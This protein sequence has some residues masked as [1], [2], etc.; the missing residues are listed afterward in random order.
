MRKNA[1]GVFFMGVTI[2][3]GSSNRTKV[4]V[5]GALC[6]ALSVVFSGFKLFSM[7]QGGS[8]TLEMAPILYFSYK[9]GFKWG[10]TAGLLSGVFQILFGG[11]VVHPIQAFLDY[12]AA[13]ACLGFAGLFGRGG[14][15]VIIGTA[16]ASAGRLACHVLSGVAFFASYAP[17]GQNVWIYSIVYN[18]SFMAPS[19]IITAIMAWALWNKFLKSF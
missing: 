10:A 19:V 6:V 3:S 8:V 2:S 9:Y 4:L 17:E 15:G 1:K 16:V 12:P 11:Y 5:E 7:P 14:R 13:L 18:V